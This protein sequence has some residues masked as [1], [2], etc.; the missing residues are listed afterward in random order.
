MQSDIAITF[1]TFTFGSHRQLTTRDLRRAIL[2]DILV[3][4]S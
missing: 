4:Y 1:L 3:I 2:I